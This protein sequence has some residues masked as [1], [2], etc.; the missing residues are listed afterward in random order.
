MNYKTIIAIAMLFAISGCITI[1]RKTEIIP[2]TTQPASSEPVTEPAGPSLTPTPP[3]P[4]DTG[5]PNVEDNN[6]PENQ[7][8]LSDTKQRIEETQ[9]TVKS[10]SF[11]TYDVLKQFYNDDGGYAE[12]D[13]KLPRLEGDYEGVPAI[14]QFFAE[15][16]NFFYDELPL[17]VLQSAGK[18]EGISD[19]YFRSAYYSLEYKENDII[20]LSALLNGGA[21]GVSWAGL[22]GNTFDLNTGRK[23]GLSDLFSVG[24]GVYLD[25]IYNYVS[26]RIYS[27][28]KDAGDDYLYFFDDPYSADGQQSIRA[29]DVNDFYLINGA[30][31]VF[32]Q[33]YALAAGAAGPLSFPIPFESMSDILALMPSTDGE[34]SPQAAGDRP[35]GAVISAEEAMG[36]VKGLFPEDAFEP[37]DEGGGLIYSFKGSSV[38]LQYENYF[39]DAEGQYHLIRHYEIVIDDPDTGEGHTA[40]YNWYRVDAVTGYVTPM[41]FEDYALNP[42]F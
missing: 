5:D 7:I 13:L 6:Y 2:S 41:F 22:E 24:E 10:V 15:K 23:L 8:D 35:G 42:D 34:N 28:I 12:L 33:K 9:A 25:F 40:T 19:G 17:D 37:A 31:V 1:E 36:I 20:S 38:M 11:S 21:G 29:Y 14:N 30:L 18:V 4:A 39:N 3:N 32:Y 26:E 27:E 16:E